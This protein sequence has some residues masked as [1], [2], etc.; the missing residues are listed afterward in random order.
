MKRPCIDTVSA[1]PL[2]NHHRGAP[3]SEEEE[4]KRQGISLHQ[5]ANITCLCFA[6][7]PPVSRYVRQEFS[8]ETKKVF[9]LMLNILSLRYVSIVYLVRIIWRYMNVRRD[10]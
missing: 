9:A 5:G 6:V 1:C 2:G 10:I 4:E 8:G 3:A 7:S